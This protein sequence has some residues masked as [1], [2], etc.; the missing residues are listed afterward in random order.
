VAGAAKERG[1]DDAVTTDEQ[2]VLDEIRIA[3]SRKA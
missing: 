1:S 2:R 3:L